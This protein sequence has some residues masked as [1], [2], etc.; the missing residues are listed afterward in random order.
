M[1]WFMETFLEFPDAGRW[2]AVRWAEAAQLAVPG[3]ALR[4]RPRAVYAV[5]LQLLN[6]T[7]LPGPDGRIAEEGGTNA[8][9]YRSALL[10]RSERLHD[11]AWSVHE[12]AHVFERL[13]LAVFDT[14]YTPQGP[15]H[16]EADASLPAAAAGAQP[17]PRPPPQAAPSALEAAASARAAVDAAEGLLLDLRLPGQAGES[18]SGGA[19]DEAAAQQDDGFGADDVA[20]AL[21]DAAGGHDAPLPDARAFL[22]AAQAAR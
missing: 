1:R 15:Q 11:R 20:G 19:D 4:S 21:P 7:R 3:W 12:W 18:S 14:R 17:P 13:W 8:E 22:A 10:H 5:A 16:A 6:G 9:Q 2:S